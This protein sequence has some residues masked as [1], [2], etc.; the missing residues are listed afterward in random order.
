MVNRSR[1]C[2]A[3]SLE[4]VA[5]EVARRLKVS[6]G[7]IGENRKRIEARLAEADVAGEVSGR[8]KRY[9]SIWSKMKRNAVDAAQLYDILAFRIVVPETRDCYAALG[10]V[11]QLWR[12]AL[13]P[14]PTSMIQAVS[15][16]IDI[17]LIIGG[18]IRTPEKALAN[19]RAGADVIVVGN[20]IEKDPELIIE[21]SE[22]VHSMNLITN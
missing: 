9:Y 20:A 6:E 4:K 11:H 15:Q 3:I 7:M 12:P 1:P 21:M 13:N 8:M 10:M 2:W 14:I 18:G 16:N 17:P 19:V 22:A 5:R